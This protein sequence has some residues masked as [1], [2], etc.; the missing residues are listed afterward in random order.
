MLKYFYSRVLM[1][2]WILTASQ[3][4]WAQS[5][6]V[7]TGIRVGIDV[8]EPISRIWQKD[9]SQ[10]EFNVDI[11]FHRV[12]FEADYGRVSIKREGVSKQSNV[13]I[14]KNNG[15]LFRIGLDYNFLKKNPSHSA[16]FIGARYAMSS[17]KDE[18]TSTIEKQEYWE[19][20]PVD[21]QQDNLKASWLE[22]VGGAKVKVLKG[23][24]VGFT[25]RFKFNKHVRNTHA[26]IPFDVPGW[27]LNELK[28]YA[29]FSYYLSY[30]IH[31]NRRSASRSKELVGD[32]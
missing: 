16:V 28:T 26:Y 6:Y 27:G 3:T 19:G 12:L 17:F 10:H 25:V 8:F 23:L 31:V 18:L 5:K 30:R 22:L 21:A 29:G 1:F 11:A 20:R 32:S 9:R 7:P 24:F 15:D 2:L 13:S 14:Y 4:S